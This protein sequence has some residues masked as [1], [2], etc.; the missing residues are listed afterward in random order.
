MTNAEAVAFIQTRRLYAHGSPAPN[1]EFSW[2]VA[3][4]NTGPW[5]GTGATLAEAVEDMQG[6]KQKDEE[7]ESLL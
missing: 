1:G 7:L 2:V 5:R 4:A 3:S 6:L